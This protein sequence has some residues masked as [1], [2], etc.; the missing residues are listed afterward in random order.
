M[1]EYVF[2]DTD[3][4]GEADY[5]ICG[6]DYEKLI[7]VCCQYGCTL[8]LMI[9]NRHTKLVKHLEAFRMPQPQNIRNEYMR[10]SQNSDGSDLDIRYYHVCDELCSLLKASANSIFDW[11]YGQG[12][13]NPEDPIVSSSCRLSMKGNWSYMLTTVRT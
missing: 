3:M 1:K 8:S 10:Y 4:R 5:D 9:A 11:V 2:Y 6:S 13:K 12:H 7:D